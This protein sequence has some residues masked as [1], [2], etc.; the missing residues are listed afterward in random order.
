M[1]YEFDGFPSRSYR[2][3]IESPI[4]TRIDRGLSWY[5]ARRPFASVNQA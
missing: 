1:A 2:S 4:V 3:P 5:S